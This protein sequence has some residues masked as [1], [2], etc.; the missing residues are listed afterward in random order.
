MS[1]DEQEYRE[2]E[3]DDDGGGREG[4]LVLYAGAWR[5]VGQVV[6]P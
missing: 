4:G 5:S 3:R 6:S 2:R 1:R